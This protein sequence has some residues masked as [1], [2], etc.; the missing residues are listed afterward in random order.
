M[1]R[2]AKNTIEASAINL[3]T[4]SLTPFSASE[5]AGEIG[6]AP[7]RLT[8]PE[9]PAIANIQACKLS[10]ACQPK[11][12]SQNAKAQIMATAA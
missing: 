6:L 7:R 1:A 9:P 8:T 3:A 2:H 5:S 4:E 10:T 12:T 11:M